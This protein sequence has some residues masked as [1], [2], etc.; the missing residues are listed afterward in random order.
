MNV[1][2]IVVEK[3]AKSGYRKY[4]VMEL[5]EPVTEP[6][7]EVTLCRKVCGREHKRKLYH[8]GKYA[9]SRGQKVINYS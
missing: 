4:A 7:E 3:V 6:G 5:I 2:A 8:D 9:G 1:E